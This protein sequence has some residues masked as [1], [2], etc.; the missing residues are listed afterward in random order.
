M[1][2]G[3]VEVQNK[4]KVPFG[5]FIETPDN[6]NSFDLVLIFFIYINA[7]FTCFHLGKENSL[8]WLEF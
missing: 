3:F 6:S 7:F 8:F 1:G 4:S 2:N 5:V